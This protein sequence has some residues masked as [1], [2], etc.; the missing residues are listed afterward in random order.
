MTG[1]PD[2][3]E[4]KTCETE[5]MT[6]GAGPEAEEKG[7]DSGEWAAEWDEAGDADDDAGGGTAAGRR[8]IRNTIAALLVAAL[9]VNILA[10]LPRIYNLETLP[11]LSKSREL[12]EREAVRKAMEAVVL[13]STDRGRGSG[14]HVSDGYILTNHHVIE[15]AAW[16]IAE[17]PGAG[18]FP[19]EVAASDPD[20]DAALLRADIGGERL[21][22]I[23]IE[24]NW[25][26]GE[27]VYVVGHPLYLERIAAE[28][29]IL[30][31][32]RLQG[33]P[34]PM[35]VVD[36]PVHRGNS[37]SPVVNE[38][39]RAIAVICAAGEITREGE[40]VQAGFAVPL[41]ALDGLIGERLPGLL[42]G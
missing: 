3:R 14:F 29:T 6:G 17:F 20:L 8:L 19:A 26:P 10:L 5:D 25:E 4:G 12:S 21:P 34:E 7:P 11:L 23:G 13:I 32:V 9:I 24:R 33:R 31:T 41:K 1:V 39:G 28:G 42:P 35:L 27:T 30:G 2:D 18:R 40:A 16:L 22:S 37:G 38:R 15:D 36:A